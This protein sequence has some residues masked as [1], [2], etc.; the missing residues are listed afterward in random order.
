MGENSL[1]LRAV[2]RVIIQNQAGEVLLCRT[3]DGKAWVPPGGTLEPG[4]D[5]KAAA[6]R[7]AA[8]EVGYRVAVERMIY[9]QEFRPSHKPE[10]VIEVAF[11]ARPLTA[12]PDAAAGRSEPA[13]PPERPWQSYYLQDV[14]GP[15][16]HVC[17][18]SREQLQDSPD[19]VYP[20]FMKHGF[21]AGGQD[22]YLGL[23][24]AK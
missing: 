1:G 5:L 16:R 24:V 9:L 7:E 17:W 10:H 19:P 8:E 23:V 11:L 14:D 21:W 3:R 12:E 2:A 13:G 20:D 22:P 4:E 15:R 18:L 6:A